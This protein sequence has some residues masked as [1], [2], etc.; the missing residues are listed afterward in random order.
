MTIDTKYNIKD[1][2]KILGLEKVTGEVCG[3]RLFLNNLSYEVYYWWDG[4][5]K[6]VYLYDDEIAP[7]EDIKRH[8]GIGK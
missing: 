7:A 3:I 5:Q 6:S 4:V 8:M 2:V 1:K